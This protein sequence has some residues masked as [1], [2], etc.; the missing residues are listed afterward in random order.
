M[1]SERENVQPVDKPGRITEPS[2]GTVGGW[3]GW[4]PWDEEAHTRTDIRECTDARCM[5]VDVNVGYQGMV[6]GSVLSQSAGVSDGLRSAWKTMLRNEGKTTSGKSLGE[7]VFG[8][9]PAE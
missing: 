4:K 7:T 1:S 9:K 5:N 2:A 3:S 6:E 8:S